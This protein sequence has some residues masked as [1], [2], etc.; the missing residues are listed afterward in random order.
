MMMSDMVVSIFDCRFSIADFR[1]L[2]ECRR[3]A[4]ALVFNRQS[5]SAIFN[6]NRFLRISCFVNSIVHQRAAA[7]RTS[8]PQLAGDDRALRPF[9]WSRRR[10][11]V[12]DR[13]HEALMRRNL[14]ELKIADCRLAIED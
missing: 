13:I 10:P 12:H 7:A 11:L 6:S 1:L 3:V 4:T 14:L 8:E 2:V 5:T 9:A